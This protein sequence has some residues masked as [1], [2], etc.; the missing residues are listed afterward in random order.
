MPAEIQSLRDYIDAM[1]KQGASDEFVVNLLQQ[2]GWSEKRIYKAFSDWYETSTGRAVPNG[3]GRTEAARDAFLYLL[4]F[5]TLGVW[6]IQLGS[7]MFNAIDRTFPNPSLDHS[8]APMLMRAMADEL[9]SII[10]A[11]PLFL[12]VSRTISRSVERQLER[13]ESPVRKWLTYI[14]LVIT[15][16]TMI[17]DIVTFTAYFLRGDIDAR[18]ICKVLTVL[19]ITGGVFTYYLDSLRSDSISSARN[20]SFAV[21]AIAMAGFGVTVGFVQIGS[22]ARQRV[23][24]QDARRVSDL[25]FLAE[26]LHG[27]W[28][29]G[30]NGFVLPLRI[31]DLSGLTPGVS[32]VDPMSGRTYKYTPLRG[33]V[34][35]LCATFSQ[36]SPA[37]IPSQWHHGTGDECFTLD[38]S[39]DVT[40]V[41]RP[42]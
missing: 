27:K 6:A 15:A 3:G 29:R 18:F 37:D 13:L 25:S 34:Y 9:A 2:H 20:R 28:L 11:F 14:A 23:A 40:V 7:L 32:T 36:P 16:S 42:W 4:A 10:V 5:I 1:K 33:T 12:L 21:A 39:D 24:S 26:G 31:Q 19:V 17:A 30:Q 35:R 38:V 41:A 8:S 22:P